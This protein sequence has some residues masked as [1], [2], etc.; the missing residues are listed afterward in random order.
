MYEPNKFLQA[1]SQFSRFL[2]PEQHA[3]S[4]I[5]SLTNIYPIKPENSYH[6]YAIKTI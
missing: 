4:V 2:T 3:D 5:F 1:T 6:C